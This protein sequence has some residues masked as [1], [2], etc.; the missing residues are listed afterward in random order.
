MARKRIRRLCMKPGEDIEPKIHT[1]Y[2]CVGKNG[3]SSTTVLWF[4]EEP[5]KG[6]EIYGI[7][8]RSRLSPY[9]NG[10]AFRYAEFNLFIIDDVYEDGYVICH[11]P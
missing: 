6:M 10:H 3:T 7:D 8:E 2:E 5:K 9:M 4:M 1:L 11:S